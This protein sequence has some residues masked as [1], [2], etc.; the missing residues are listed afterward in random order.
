MSAEAEQGNPQKL[1]RIASPTPL[2]ME[3]FEELIDLVCDLLAK[4]YRTSE[5]REHLKTEVGLEIT[6]TALGNLITRARGVM[7]QRVGRSKNELKSESTFF[8][9]TLLRDPNVSTREKIIARSRLDNILGLEPQFGPREQADS[10]DDIAAKARRALADMDTA[11][12]GDGDMVDADQ[13]SPSKV[14]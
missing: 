12:G 3:A 14:A 8:Y 10:A 9:E 4:C 13:Q 6:G 7:L 2:V 5:I 1:P 11:T